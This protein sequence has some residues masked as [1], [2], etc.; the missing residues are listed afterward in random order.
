MLEVAT[1]RARSSLVVGDANALPFA[2]GSFDAAVAVTLLEFVA[3]PPAAVAEMCR[4]V[5]S[6]GRVVIGALNPRSP[7]GVAHRRTLRETPW[8]SARFLG[9]HQ[10]R[11]LADSCGAATRHGVLFVPGPIPN[12]ARLGPVIESA[13]RLVPHVGAFQVLAIDRPSN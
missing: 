6:G 10:L 4:V 13:G 12:L 2:S 7:W 5:R 9:K 11:A 3:D 1:P 8:S